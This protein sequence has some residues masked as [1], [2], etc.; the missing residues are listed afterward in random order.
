MRKIL[1]SSVFKF[2]DPVQYQAYDKIN[3]RLALFSFNGELKMFSLEKR[4]FVGPYIR[5]G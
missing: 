4:K 2:N 5:T 1:I 3:S